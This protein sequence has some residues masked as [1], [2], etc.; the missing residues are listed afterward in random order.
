LAKALNKILH[1]K[2]ELPNAFNVTSSS[3]LTQELA[4]IEVD[5]HI[6]L[7]SFDIQNIHT[8]IPVSDLLNTIRDII[9]RNNITTKGECTE[10][11]NLLEL[12]IDHNYIQHNDQYYK[13]TEG[14]AMGAPTSAILAEVYI[15]FLEYT[16]IANT[17]KKQQIADYH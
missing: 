17:L 3:S 7:C 4:S 5:E 6:Q 15:Q 10:I 13:Q 16:E 8:N 12:I 1:K 14:L 11:L 9:T 2:L